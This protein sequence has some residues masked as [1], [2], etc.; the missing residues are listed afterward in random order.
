MLRA[1]AFSVAAA[2]AAGAGSISVASARERSLLQAWEGDLGEAG[3]NDTPV[4]HVVKLLKDMGKTLDKEMEEDE[5]QHHKLACW[6]NSNSY[7]KDQSIAASVAKVSELESSIEGFAAKS[8]ELKHTIKELEDELEKDRTSLAEA[9]ALR[10]KQL[11]EFHS[12][13]VEAAQAVS[14]LKAAIVVLSKHSGPPEGGFK[15]EKDSWASFLS[16]KTRAFP[17]EESHD[18]DADMMRSLDDYMRKNGVDPSQAAP[19]AL[20]S[21][22]PTQKFLQQ[23]GA[24]A[25]ASEEW[26]TS[27]EVVV[28]RAMRAATLFMQAHHTETYMPAYGAQSGQILGV[29]KQLKDDMEANLSDSQKEEQARSAQFAELRAAKTAEIENGGKMLEDK[30]DELATAASA[31]AQAREDLAKENGVLSEEQRFL[32]NLKETCSQ[33]SAD[34]EER[35]KARTGEIQAVSEAIEILTSDEA[36]D[37]ASGTFGFVQAGFQRHASQDRRRAAEVLRSIARRTHNPTLSILATSVELDAFAKVKK[38]IDAM[39]AMLKEQQAAEVK[40]ADWC[41]AEFHETEVATAR[42]MDRKSDLEAKAESLEQDIKALEEGLANAKAQMVQQQVDLQR[43]S[44]DRMAAN[45]EFQQTIADQKTTMTVLKHAL[46]RLAQFYGLVQ[47]KAKAS[48]GQSQTPP[49]QQKEYKTQG[50]SV[51]VMNLIQKLIG[52]AQILMNDARKSEGNAQ[53]AYEQLVSDTNASVKALSEDIVAK[54]KA[55]GK[56]HKGLMQVLSDRKATV[57]EL[58]GLAKYE[59]DLHAECDY[60]LKNFEARQTARSQ[61]MEA[62]QQAKQILSG[63]DF[64][65]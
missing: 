26:T 4:T 30:K 61:E 62:M 8:G 13:E 54:T 15:T 6:C 5:D 27:D 41:K 46:D 12:Q 11:A 38:A 65:K 50:G 47:S 28:R 45:L 10:D 16:T 55:K 51:G 9:Q 37:A 32:K 53:A 60:I 59:G 33:A 48:H 49:V 29:L 64:G 36:K 25:G 3:G 1:A 14:Q 39:V 7:E 19:V 63:A 57:K 2:S 40:K 24:A 34:F 35:K 43:A 18:E 31:H 22:K 42:A 20:E 23:G 17:W 21:A 52:D 58:E 44:E 56:A